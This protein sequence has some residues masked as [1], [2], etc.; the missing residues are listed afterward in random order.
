[1]RRDN[2]I[3]TFRVHYMAAALEPSSAAPADPMSPEMCKR[4]RLAREAF[5]GLVDVMR[6]AGADSKTPQAALPERNEE[7]GTAVTPFSGAEALPAGLAKVLG[8]KDARLWTSSM[9][10]LRDLFLSRHDDQQDM[11]GPAR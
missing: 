5:G 11:S 3:V 8:S 4:R 2:L 10:D 1:M 6:T 7:A 9:N